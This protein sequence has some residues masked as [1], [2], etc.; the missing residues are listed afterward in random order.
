MT[1]ELILSPHKQKLKTAV[2]ECVDLVK[3]VAIV[4]EIAPGEAALRLLRVQDS[5][6]VIKRTAL[7]VRTEAL[8]KQ[9]P[10]RKR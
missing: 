1:T 5:N 10:P 8:I 3:A 9:N 2:G 6:P 4:Q 7:I